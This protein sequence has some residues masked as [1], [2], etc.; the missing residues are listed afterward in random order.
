MD[1]VAVAFASFAIAV[2]A[3]ALGWRASGRARTL[4]TQVSETERAMKAQ[5]GQLSR[6][7]ADR[8]FE[9]EQR[10]GELRAILAYV[11]E[12]YLVVDASGLIGPERSRIMTT[13][14]GE[15]TQTTFEAFVAQ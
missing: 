15:L 4:A 9:V 7:L 10:H 12:G 2:I 14:F 5:L 3:S 6:A 13:W 11:N 1:L 8:A